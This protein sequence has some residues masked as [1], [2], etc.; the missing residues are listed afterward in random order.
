MI[1]DLKTWPEYFEEVRKGTKEFE[2]RK[3]DRPFKVGDTLVLREYYSLLKRYTGK[4]I[5]VRVS[6]ILYGPGFGIEPGYCIMSIG[7]QEKLKS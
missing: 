1:H 2:I 4:A 3:Y 6:Y 7:N 5:Q